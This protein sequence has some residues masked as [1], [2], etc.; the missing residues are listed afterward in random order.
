[1]LIARIK[2][3][4]RKEKRFW[5]RGEKQSFRW[6]DVTYHVKPDCIYG[7]YKFF[8][9]LSLSAIDYVQGNGEPVGFYR[10]SGDY[11]VGRKNLD[12]ISMVISRWLQDVIKNFQ[13]Y[14]IILLISSVAIGVANIVVTYLSNS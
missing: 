8:G 9:L 4:N 12:T 6:K 10:E 2:C 14:V 7:Y 1:M 3:V 13:L 11:L 5:V